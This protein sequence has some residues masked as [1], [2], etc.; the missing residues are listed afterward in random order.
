MSKTDAASDGSESPTKIMGLI[1][2]PI[3]GMG[4]AVGLKGTDGSRILNEAI[5]LGAK[6]VAPIRA[7]TFLSELRQAR[8]SVKLLLGAGALGE[9]EAKA[10]GFDYN[11]LG[12]RKTKTTAEDTR[13]TARMMAVENITLLVFCGGDGT[14]RDILNAIDTKFPVLGV[15]TGVKMHSGVFA[16]NPQAAARV[17]T[18][19][20][21]GHL[22]LKEVEVMD[23]DE[24]AFRE[25]RL[26][27]ELYGYTLT[28]YEPSLIQANKLASPITESELRN[29][30]AIAVYI[31]EEMAP[32]TVYII[33]PGTTTRAIADL[34]DVKKT[35]LGADLFLNKKLV[36]QD[37]NEEQILKTIDDKK[38][39]IIV[40]PIGGQ[41]F[42][43]GRGNQQLSSKVIRQVGLD[44][45]IVIA[46]ESK[47][48][49]LNGLKVD[50]G[51]T[52]LDAT[53]MKY[54]MTVITDYKTKRPV[55]VE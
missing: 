39:K 16:V 10:C 15:P 9:D 46:T 44:N 40:T 28:P 4:G 12:K 25:G 42:I 41:G 29:Q 54:G 52:D 27:A 14:A 38:A 49:S 33:G 24:K 55:K 13:E 37:V 6:P 32:D 34:L 21:L 22:P 5:R 31:I 36:A 7:E 35:L 17:A 3:A 23:V 1:V 11:I 19:F 48:R 26:S 43:F 2:N 47:L 50:T 18:R 8:V 45:I 53:L 30:A 51:D 20:L